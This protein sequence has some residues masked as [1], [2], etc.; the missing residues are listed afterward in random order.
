M[1]RSNDRKV[2][3][4]GEPGQG[5]DVES[6]RLELALAL[7]G[8]TTAQFVIA[9]VVCLVTSY[10][11]HLDLLRILP[12]SVKEISNTNKWWYEW[13][14]VSFHALTIASTYLVSRQWRLYRS[15]DVCSSHLPFLNVPTS[16]WDACCCYGSGSRG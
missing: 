15:R 12:E 2:H 14:R 16:S 4:G 5:G 1:R 11:T 3:D 6:S 10:E 13:V 7:L 9:S 8:R